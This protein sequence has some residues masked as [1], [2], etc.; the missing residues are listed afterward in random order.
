MGLWG[1]CPP[2]TSNCLIFLVTSEPHKLKLHVVVY[3]KRTYRPIAFSLSLK[4]FLLSFVAPPCTKSWRRHYVSHH[5][6][7]S[8]SG[9]VD[10]ST[11]P[12]CWLDLSSRRPF[13]R[14][15]PRFYLCF[16]VFA[17]VYS[18]SSGLSTQP[19]NSAKEVC[20]APCQRARWHSACDVSY[21]ERYLFLAASLIFHTYTTNSRDSSSV[22]VMQTS[23]VGLW[24]VT[25]VMRVLDSKLI[26]EYSHI[27]YLIWINKWI[28]I[29]FTF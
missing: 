26:L 13:N 27:D 28:Y 24:Q 15:E 14:F 4:V 18:M 3:P 23:E 25:S 6:T 12:Y 1:T 20:A 9:G 19:K 16:D 10:I 5:V 7:R 2:S 8:W 11:M 29:H 21:C 17:Q 22:Y